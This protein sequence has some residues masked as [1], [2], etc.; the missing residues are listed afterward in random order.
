MKKP[1]P[2]DVDRDVIVDAAALLH[3]R[4]TPAI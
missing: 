4:V 3:L 1:C 2:F